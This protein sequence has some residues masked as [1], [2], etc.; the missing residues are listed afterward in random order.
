MSYPSSINDAWGRE[1]FQRNSF[2]PTL[3]SLGLSDNDVVFIS[4]VDEILNSERVEYIKTSYDLQCINQMDMTTYFGNFYN[5]EI[6][7]K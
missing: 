1:K 7:N 6:T 4:D 3:Y 5:K 2:M